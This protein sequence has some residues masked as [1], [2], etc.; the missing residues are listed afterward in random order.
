MFANYFG[1]I[2]RVL[3]REINQK[4]SGLREGMLFICF[5]RGVRRVGKLVLEV[6]TTN[7]LVG[8][9]LAKLGIGV[10]LVGNIQTEIFFNIDT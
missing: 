8:G 1:G 2:A 7:N 4:Q 6:K 5:E 3:L 9:V 10:A